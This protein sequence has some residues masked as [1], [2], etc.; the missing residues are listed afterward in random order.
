MY[1]QPDHR[2]DPEGRQWAGREAELKRVT[3]LIGPI[4]YQSDTSPFS[5]A[6]HNSSR[7]Y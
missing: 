7:A 1:R 3:N 6:G 4:C 2:A 5:D